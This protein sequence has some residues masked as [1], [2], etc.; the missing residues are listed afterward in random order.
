[1]AGESVEELLAE[2][3]AVTGDDAAEIYAKGNSTTVV[4]GSL[5]ETVRHVLTANGKSAQLR[6]TLEETVRAG[7]GV[8][9]SLEEMLLKTGLTGWS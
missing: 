7:G 3:Y 2:L 5:F 9:E 4:D 8:G 6:E 1:M